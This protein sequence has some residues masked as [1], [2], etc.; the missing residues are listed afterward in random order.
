[1]SIFVALLV[2]FTSILFTFQYSLH[3]F[4]KNINKKPQPTTASQLKIYETKTSLK[5]CNTKTLKVTDGTVKR[6]KSS[7][8]KV[9]TVKNGKVTALTKDTAKITDT[10]TNSKKSTF[11]VKVKGIIKV[12]GVDVFL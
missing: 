2:Y 4:L 12:I 1:M 8:K 10:I 6:W 11:K 5:A 7:D 3:N 9:A